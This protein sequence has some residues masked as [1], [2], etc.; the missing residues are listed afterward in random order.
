MSALDCNQLI[1]AYTEHLT[2]RLRAESVEGVCELTLPFLNRHND[3]IQIYAELDG[4][5]I[6][7]TDDGFTLSDLRAGGVNIEA[8]KCQSVIEPTLHGLG[9]QR[10]GDELTVKTTPER[11]GAQINALAQVM[12]ILDGIWV[13]VYES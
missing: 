8:V 6:K 3:H 2:S 13:T 12:L 7:L 11:L 9:V 5:V 4:G 1:T 10:N